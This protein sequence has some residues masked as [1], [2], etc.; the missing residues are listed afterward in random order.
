MV[1]P[2]PTTAAGNHYIFMK[3]DYDTRWPEVF[4]LQLTDSKSIADQLLLMFTRV[5][6]PEQILMA[7]GKIFVSQLLRELY[8]LLVIQSMTTT[9]Y[10]P[11]T[12]G[13]VERYNGTWP[14]HSCLEN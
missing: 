13:L 5:G 12:D 6:V 2:L 8:Q 1:G 9:S 7:C 4:L 14:Y 10:H 11:A 3:V